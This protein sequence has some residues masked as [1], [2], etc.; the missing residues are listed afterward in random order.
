MLPRQWKGSKTIRLKKL[1]I[2]VL[3]TNLRIFWNSLSTKSVCWA[4]DCKFSFLF[5]PIRVYF[6][7]YFTDHVTWSSINVFFRK[8][9]GLSS[10]YSFSIKTWLAVTEAEQRNFRQTL[11]NSIDFMENLLDFFF[12]NQFLE[13]VTLPLNLS[14]LCNETIKIRQ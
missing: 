4:L 14:S 10:S 13:L 9:C 12:L 2:D 6:K 1:V 7:P 3:I 5:N 11:Y 8:N